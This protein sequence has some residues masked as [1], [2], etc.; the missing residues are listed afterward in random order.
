LEG[1]CVMREQEKVKL[2]ECLWAD[3]KTHEQ[4]RDF[5]LLGRGVDTGIIAPSMQNVLAHDY[6]VIVELQKANAELEKECNKLVNKIEIADLSTWAIY[7]ETPRGQA[8]ALEQQAKS[9]KDFV[10]SIEGFSEGYIQALKE[11]GK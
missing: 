4:K 2:S 11:Q 8:F 7:L 5:L 1:D 9:V 10:F 6:N 3:L